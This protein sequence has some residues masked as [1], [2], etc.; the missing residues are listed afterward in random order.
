ME[1]FKD[2]PCKIRPALNIH[3]QSIH[4]YFKGELA[5]FKLN[6]KIRSIRNSRIG[7]TQ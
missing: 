4:A 6:Q 2:T 5:L 7:Y 3:I 1:D